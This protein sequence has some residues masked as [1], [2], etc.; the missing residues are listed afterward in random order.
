MFDKHLGLS[1]FFCLCLPFFT[2]LEAFVLC[3]FQ[4]FN[5]VLQLWEL[6]IWSELKH[7]LKVCV[8]GNLAPFPTTI[9]SFCLNP[10]WFHILTIGKYSLTYLCFYFS[11]P[12][13]RTQYIFL[14]TWS[15][16]WQI[17]PRI[18]TGWV[19]GALGLS[20]AVK[21]SVVHTC[22][23][24]G[25]H[26]GLLAGCYEGSGSKQPCPHG[27]VACLQTHSSWKWLQAITGLH[28]DPATVPVTKDVTVHVAT[29]DMCKQGLPCA[30]GE[31]ALCPTFG[32]EP[33][34]K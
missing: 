14:S 1:P 8:W 19:S 23:S 25:P 18:P 12:L 13:N 21:C 2:W 32:S 6:C 17:V 3:C 29:S 30:L 33:V 4:P 26:E 7:F 22:V 31:R 27:S 28:P 15:F 24:P 16:P 5:F 11:L 34:L 9:P 10:W 20:G